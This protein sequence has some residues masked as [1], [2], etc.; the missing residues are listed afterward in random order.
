[1]VETVFGLPGTGRYLVQGA[2]D[3]D[4][5]LVMGMI[6][7]YAVLTLLCNLLADLLYGWLDPGVRH[8]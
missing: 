4:Y 1:V 8:D 6:I 3:R 5:P 7:V 2:I